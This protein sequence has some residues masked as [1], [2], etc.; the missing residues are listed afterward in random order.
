MNLR[1]TRA[2][3]DVD[4]YRHNVA[5]L[6]DVCR[7]AAFCAVLK[8]DAYGHGVVEL[9]PVA[10]AAGAD[11]CAVA[12]VEEGVEL[13]AMGIDVPILVLSQPVDGAEEIV[14]H[15]LTATVDTPEGVQRLAV[16]ARRAGAVVDVH[17]NV[18]TGMHRVGA[19]P[20]DVAELIERIDAAAECRLGGVWTHYARADELDVATTEDQ[21]EIFERCVGAV[22]DRARRGGL[23]FHTA[24]SAAA[25]T[26]PTIRGDLVRCGIATYGITPGP[27]IGDDL[28]LRPVMALRSAVTHLQTRAAGEAVSYGHRYAPSA[29]T[30]LATVP[31][32]YADGV[33]RDAGVRGVEVLVGG[34]RCPIVGTVTMDQ[35]LVDVGSVPGVAVGDQVTLI[36]TDGTEAITAEEVAGRLDTIGYEV[37]CA[38]GRRVPRVPRPAA[39]V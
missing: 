29:T 6:A 4:A 16:A 8:A 14:A 20:R 17:L 38:V 5:R 13:R 34:R 28:G 27:G 35:L 21:H 3:I 33:R 24:N 23:V 18:D 1:P 30:V 37:V 2:E 22:L 19:D 9:G 12:L 11:W 7:P 15:G 25:I 39:A 31:V 36:G 26:R 32:G 10:V